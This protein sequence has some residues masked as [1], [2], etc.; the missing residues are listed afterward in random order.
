[1]KKM[2]QLGKIAFLAFA[3]SFASCS[4]DSDGGSTG[5]TASEGTISAKVDGNTITTLAIATNATIIGSAGFQLLALSGADATGKQL[6][7]SIS[8]YAGAGTYGDNPNDGPFATFTYTALDLNNPSSS[9]NT[10][11][12]PYEDDQSTNGTITITEQ[13][14]TKIKG[15][16]SF[17]GKNIPGAFKEVTNGSF[18]INLTQA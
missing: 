15:T 8:S 16:F 12:A 6:T 2:K 10:W 18:N 14:A 5:G 13:T 11:I 4:S 9:N 1:M 7:V 17:K 3:L